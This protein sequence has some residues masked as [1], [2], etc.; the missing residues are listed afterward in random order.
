MGRDEEVVLSVCRGHRIEQRLGGICIHRKPMRRE[1]LEPLP[2]QIGT[3]LDSGVGRTFEA[4]RNIMH[5]Y[6]SARHRRS[7]RKRTP[8]AVVRQNPEIA[9]ERRSLPDQ[10]DASA[11]VVRD[12]F[13]AQELWC[14][15][16]TRSKEFT[17]EI[18]QLSQ[19]DDALDIGRPASHHDRGKDLARFTRTQVERTCA[20]REAL[21]RARRVDPAGATHRIARERITSGLTSDRIDIRGTVSPQP[22]KIVVAFSRR[23]WVGE[24]WVAC[25]MVCKC[26]EGRGTP[27]LQE[28]VANC[29]RG[30]S[31]SAE[32]PLIIVV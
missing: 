22:S 9:V 4:R 17:N 13:C 2:R 1:V 25:R 16:Q 7:H 29:R 20:H 6:F 27:F 11:L 14:I 24:V 8:N 23:Y 5:L 21:V 32:R 26:I 12:V 15:F 18:R 31:I 19:V 28:H 10:L 3:S 30:Q